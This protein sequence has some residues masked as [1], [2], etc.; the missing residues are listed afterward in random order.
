[1]IFSCAHYSKELILLYINY[2]NSRNSFKNVKNVLKS[3]HISHNFSCFKRAILKIDNNQQIY[4]AQL[5]TYALY[6]FSTGMC[7]LY[8]LSIIYICVC[9]YTCIRVHMHTRSYE[10]KKEKFC[11]FITLTIKVSKTA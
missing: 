7:L 10:R 1:M 4:C 6:A 3:V 2:C 11:Y 9:V 8:L 5:F